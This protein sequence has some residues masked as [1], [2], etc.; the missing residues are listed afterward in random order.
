MQVVSS[1]PP[2]VREL[3]DLLRRIT[4]QVKDRGPDSGELFDASCD[5]EELV[6]RYDR[7]LRGA[8]IANNS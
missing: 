6:D 7:S 5:G 1:N 8:F 4:Q 3:I 2:T